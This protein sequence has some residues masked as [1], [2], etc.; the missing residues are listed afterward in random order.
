MVEHGK[1]QSKIEKTS[2]G[3]VGSQRKKYIVN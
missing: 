1:K 3:L 2:V